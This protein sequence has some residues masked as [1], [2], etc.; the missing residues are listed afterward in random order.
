MTGLRHPDYPTLLEALAEYGSE[1]LLPLLA[2]G[3]VRAKFIDKKTGKISGAVGGG[4]FLK[5]DASEILRTGRTRNDGREIFIWRQEVTSALAAQERANQPKPK[6]VFVDNVVDMQPAGTIADENRCRQ[7]LESQ[8]LLSPDNNPRPRSVWENEARQKFNVS[9]RGFLRAW[10]NAIAAT[11][12]E[13]WGRAGAK[14]K[15]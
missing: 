11:G 9:G 5:Q 3:K 2:V 1:T 14:S 8:M 12:A 15:R 6:L 7:W 10:A 13:A 4:L